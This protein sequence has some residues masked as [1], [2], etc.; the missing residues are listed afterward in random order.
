MY[1]KLTFLFTMMMMVVVTLDSEGVV[2]LINPIW[3]NK[4]CL[5]NQRGRDSFPS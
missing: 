3:F 2:Y 5:N 1:S 4:T